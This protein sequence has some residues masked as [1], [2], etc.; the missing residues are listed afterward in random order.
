MTSLA[1]CAASQRK[2]VVN[3]FTT[4]T[5]KTYGN[6]C[7]QNAAKMPNHC[8]IHIDLNKLHTHFCAR[9]RP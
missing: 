2:R 5:G 1:R 4:I 8:T 6:L 7:R 3:Q 9:L